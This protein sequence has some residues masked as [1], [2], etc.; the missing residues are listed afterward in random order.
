MATYKKR[1]NS[2]ELRIYFNKKLQA[3]AREHIVRLTILH[4]VSL[5]LLWSSNFLSSRRI[6]KKTGS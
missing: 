4:P 3:A 2:Y 6:L 5:L 1:G